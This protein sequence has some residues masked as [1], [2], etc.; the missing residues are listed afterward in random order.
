MKGFQ[1]MHPK[2]LE[3]VFNLSPHERYVYFI[4][5]VADFQEVWGLKQDDGWATTGDDNG[6]LY[7]KRSIKRCMEF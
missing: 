6:T 3:R 7:R 5:H 2:K 4:K 1:Y